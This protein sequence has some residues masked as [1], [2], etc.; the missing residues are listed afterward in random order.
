MKTSVIFPTYNASETIV[1]LLSSIQQQTLK[2]D[3][4]LAIDSS[5]SDNTIEILKARNISY[6]IIKTS[7]FN[8]GTTRKYATSLVDADIYIFLTQDVILAN[9]DAFKNILNAF[10]DE[11]I[12]CAYGRQLPNENANVLAAHLRLFAYPKTSE[13][14]SYDRRKKLGLITCSNSDN[15]AAYRKK[16]LFETGGI[17]ENIIFGEDMHVAA[18]MLIQGWKVAYIADAM[19]YHSHNYTI[20]QEF[21]RYFDTGVFHAMNPWILE[22]F[23]NNFSNAI[24]YFKSVILYCI[25]SKASTVL[26]KAIVS[27]F[28]KYFGFCIGKHYKLVP[29]SLRKKMS[30]Y[31]HY[32]DMYDKN[33]K[34]K[35]YN[36]ISVG[37]IQK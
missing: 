32:W 26:P 22:N 14:R 33:N 1:S 4:I 18:N 20:L 31:N 15:F 2:P 9:E 5:S 35:S 24:E 6:H 13:I 19:I 10:K 21:K 28:A 16:A 7:D 8:H 34:L 3:H 37:G 27:V 12:G 25:N 29:F 30:M 11:K 17:P 23:N 36:A